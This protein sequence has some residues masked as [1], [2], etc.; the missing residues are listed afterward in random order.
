MYDAHQEHLKRIKYEKIKKN[1][2]I[3]KNNKEYKLKLKE[4]KTKPADPFW[5][6][7]DHMSDLLG[8]LGARSN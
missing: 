4:V 5:V 3:L 6:W 7:N 2:K 8:I 1:F